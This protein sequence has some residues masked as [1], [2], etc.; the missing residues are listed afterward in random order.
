MKKQSILLLALSVFVAGNMFGQLV[1]RE[2]VGKVVYKR[3]ARPQAGDYGL[4]F[5]GAFA[6]SAN[7]DASTPSFPYMNNY[8]LVKKNKFLHFLENGG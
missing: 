7:N 3:D 1:E 4:F 5:S 6:G 8:T 2:N